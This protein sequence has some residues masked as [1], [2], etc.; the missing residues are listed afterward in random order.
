MSGFNVP[1]VHAPNPTSEPYRWR[2]HA[3]T[4]IMIA[5]L[6][7]EEASAQE[8]RPV[9]R[10]A[11][12][13]IMTYSG[14]STLASEGI[15]WATSPDGYTWTKSG[16]PII[17]QGHAGVS[18]GVGRSCLVWPGGS[19]L[20]VFFTDGIP[21]NWLRVTSTDG[22]STWGSLATI[23]DRSTSPTGYTGY[24]N[25]YIAMDG[26]VW[27]AI[28]ELSTSGGGYE[29]FS[30]TSTDLTTWT[31][32]TRLT[33]LQIGTG[34][35]SADYW[36]KEDGLYHIFCHCST[37]ESVVPTDI[38]HFTSSDFV[39]CD[40]RG[41]SLPRSLEINSGHLGTIDQTGDMRMV[42]YL[43]T[44]FAFYARTNNESNPL[45]GDSALATYQGSLASLYN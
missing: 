16:A 20:H 8:P 43:D 2:R 3:A 37:T 32:R 12:D 30:Y 39:S 38:Y 44:R 34:S 22:G 42:K 21:G 18:G 26:A 45:S 41:I 28:L 24:N 23:L 19:T 4:P 27:R 7:W 29:T 15:G 5:D 9:Y 25:S 1:G 36:E 10:G 31:N 14:G 40:S 6:A 17:G 13:W 11:G 35:S 33:G